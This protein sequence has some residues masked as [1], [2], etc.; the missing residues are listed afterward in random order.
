MGNWTL[1]LLI[2]Q[3]WTNW[4][5]IHTIYIKNTEIISFEMYFIKF[6][7]SLKKLSSLKIIKNENKSHKLK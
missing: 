2:K 6:I 7:N 3:M 1:L 4:P 5:I